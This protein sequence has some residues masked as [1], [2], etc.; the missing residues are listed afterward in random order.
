MTLFCLISQLFRPHLLIKFS[1]RQATGAGA[2]TQGWSGV[3]ME[4][5][6]EKEWRDVS[7]VKEV[8]DW[9]WRELYQEKEWRDVLLVKEVSE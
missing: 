8:S 7:L 1:F 5:N 6:Q 3:W 2:M 4:L 9:V